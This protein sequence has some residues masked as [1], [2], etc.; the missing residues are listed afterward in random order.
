MKTREYHRRIIYKY[1]YHYFLNLKLFHFF[2]LPFSLKIPRDLLQQCKK[3]GQEE[4]LTLSVK[5]AHTYV[6]LQQ[7]YSALYLNS[8]GVKQQCYLGTEVEGGPS[9]DIVPL[10]LFIYIFFYILVCI[11]TI[12]LSLYLFSVKFYFF[13]RYFI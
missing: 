6:I 8:F 3:K 12:F 10:K 5:N 4:S 11:I 1:F 2:S 7:C 13:Q 9:K